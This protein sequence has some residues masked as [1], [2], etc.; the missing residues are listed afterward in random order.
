MEELAELMALETEA[1]T[2]LTALATE[3][4][5]DEVSM[6]VLV[7]ATVELTA[8]ELALATAELT[9]LETEADTE[10]T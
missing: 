9:A 4:D 2:E 10:L 3:A 1:L 8:V 6:E 5:A 7:G